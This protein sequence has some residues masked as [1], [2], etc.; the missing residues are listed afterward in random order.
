MSVSTRR[1]FL[2]RTLLAL[3]F[4]GTALAGQ[5]QLTK[6]DKTLVWNEDHKAGDLVSW[7]GK[8]DADGYASGYGILTWYVPENARET[9]S[10]VP[11]KRYRISSR[12]S[13]T[14]VHGKFE[15]APPH[16]TP[17]AAVEPAKPKKKGW[18]SIFKSRST[19]TPAP[20][21]ATPKPRAKS[22]S[23]I[24]E[25]PQKPSPSA[26]NPAASPALTATPSPSAANDS[27]DSLMHA[28]SSLKLG[29]PAVS[30]SPSPAA[31]S[32]ATTPDVSLEPEQPASPSPSPQ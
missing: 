4:S 13:G 26:T 9:G 16:A 17:Q 21:E 2:Y 28:P 32:S 7:S 20:I 29:S 30:P 25:T 23:H 3:L 5:Y 6:D 15:Q 24:E 22:P 8:R 10:N 18:F 12:V 1:F 11:R 14:M 19:P 27:L 31:P